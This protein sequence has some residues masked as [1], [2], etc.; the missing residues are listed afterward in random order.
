MKN[1]PRRLARLVWFAWTPCLAL[2]VTAMLFRV[3]GG[4]AARLFAFSWVATCAFIWYAAAQMKGLLAERAPDVLVRR[5]ILS[6][7]FTASYFQL[8]LASREPE[9]LA[10]HELREHASLLVAL[11]V[12]PLIVMAALFVLTMTRAIRL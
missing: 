2:L 7:I 4:W 6:L 12:G 3:S 5:N 1:E 8:A 9:V 10:D 11:L